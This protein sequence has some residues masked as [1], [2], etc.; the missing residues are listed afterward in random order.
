MKIILL[1]EDNDLN[2]DMLSRRLTRKGFDVILAVNGVQGVAMAISESPD[3]VL[4]D[5]NLPDIDGW[6]ATRQIRMY[7]TVQG[8]E[9]GKQRH[10]PIIAV[11][12][13]ATSTDCKKAIDAGCDE[14][15]SKPIMLTS[16]L[17]KMNELLRGTM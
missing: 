15:E 2:R 1:V 14:Y 16:L 6:E 7:E 12:A 11:T 10:I 13:H 4:M 17:E 5:M 8:K 9:H 3:L